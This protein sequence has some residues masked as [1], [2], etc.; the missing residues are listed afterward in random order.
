MPGPL[1]TIVDGYGSALD[2]PADADDG[3]AVAHVGADG[4]FDGILDEVDQGL[5]D[6]VF[7]DPQEGLGAGVDLDLHAMFEAGDS[8]DEERPPRRG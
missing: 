7:V 4:S 8:F 1:S 6:L 2:L 3:L 5:L